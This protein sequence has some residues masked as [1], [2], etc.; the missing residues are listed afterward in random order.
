MN[1]ITPRALDG[2]RVLEIAGVA[3]A[4]CGRLLADLGAEVI[5]VEPPGGDPVRDAGGGF[6]HAYMNAGKKSVT[7]A[8]GTTAGR[9]TLLELARGTDV[10]IESLA[11]GRLAALGLGY[12][13]LRQANPALV[14][15]SITA[16]GQSG[17]HRDFPAADIVAM[18]MG[19]AMVVTG[20]PADPPVTLAGS[21]ACVSA[22]TLAAA[23]SLIALRHAALTGHGQHVDISMQEAVLAVTSICG[24]GKWLDDGI[25]P[26]RFGTGT[27]SSVPSGTYPCIDG[28]IYLMVNRPLHWKA[29]ARWVHETT[30]N[31]EILDPM[32]EGSSLLRQP[33]RELLDIFIREHTA[34]FTVEELYR[35]GQRRHLAMSPLRTVSEM[36]RDTHL[37][38]RGFFVESAPPDGSRARMPG[39]AYRLSRT[40]C[41][42]RGA[43]PRAGEHDAQIAALLARAVAPRDAA[44]CL[45]PGAPLAGV[46]VIEFG[47][48]M[49]GPWIGRFMAWCG[50]DVIKVESRA[51]PD[52]TRL[53]I[54]PREPERGVQPELSP[55]FTDWNAGKRFVSLDLT[56]P[57]GAALARRLVGAADVVIDNN[58]TGMLA[59]FGLGFG[60]LAR[61]KPALVLFSSTG[62]GDSGPDHHYVS[63]GPNIETLSGIAS[64]SGFPHRA[65]TMTQFAYPDPLSA[66]HGLCAIMAALEHR[67]DSGEGQH[68]DLS[69]LESTVAAIGHLALACLAEGREPQRLG[70]AS[71]D[72]APQGC[73]PCLGDD[74]WCVIAVAGEPEWACF[75]ELLGHPEWLRDQ[76]FATA[77]AR[78]AHAAELDRLIGAWTA[79]QDRYALMRRLAAAGIAAGVV[80][81]VEDQLERDAHLAERGFFERIVHLRK[82]SVLAPG[83]PLGLTATPGRTRDTGRTRGHDNSEVFRGLLGLSGP[84]FDRAVA[85]G[86]IEAGDE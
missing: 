22:S 40:P 7:L 17:P 8:L 76:R 18:A 65:C 38:A 68:I 19:G 14:L 74:R 77:A 35:E 39:P 82:G 10:L 53:Y 25:V 16:F 5:L 85:A 2:R 42:P 20:D 56:V 9:D 36:C 24:A 73:Y 57:A 58:S 61:M 49:A 62:Y 46:R 32:F 27:F 59:K 12:D 34:R 78:R 28:E 4:Y 37:A 72:H 79:S 70:N 47:A 33:Y 55:W 66:L 45:T 43:A 41:A 11:P 75:C 31:E 29:L 51:Y 52:V 21:Q 63:W 1:S 50:A 80:Q 60:E 71:P 30:G 84:E 44:R 81:D 6:L 54:P 23:G 69:Q 26:K 48:G 13:R 83:I 64:V 67:R 86:A 3:G 15:T